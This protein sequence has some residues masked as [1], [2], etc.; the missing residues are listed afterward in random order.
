MSQSLLGRVVPLDEYVETL[1]AATL[2][3]V[4]AVLAE[5]LSPEPVVAIVGS[6]T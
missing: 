1:R 5:V 4:N 3:E 6:G 2:D